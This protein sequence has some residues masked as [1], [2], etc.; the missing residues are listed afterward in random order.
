[1]AE[2]N[3][4]APRST[5]TGSSSRSTNTV[6]VVLPRAEFGDG[7]CATRARGLYNVHVGTWSVSTESKE[8]IKGRHQDEFPVDGRR[9]RSMEH[10]WRGGRRG[11]RGCLT[12]PRP[13]WRAN[14]QRRR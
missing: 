6:L 11:V 12:T 3:Q 4:A 8:L 10:Y 13:A 14:A 2:G 1:M 7:P 5:P 9:L